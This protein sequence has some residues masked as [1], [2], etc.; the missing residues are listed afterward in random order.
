M[1][2]EKPD[3][4]WDH[5]PWWCQPWSIILTGVLIISTSWLLFK[6]VWLS[7]LVAIPISVW[8]GFF[9]ILFPKLAYQ[10]RN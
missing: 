4:V 8:M 10:T 6:I 2:S 7:I 9:V 3:S 5:K 1:S